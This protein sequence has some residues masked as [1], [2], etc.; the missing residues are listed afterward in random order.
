MV[1]S[2]QK[3]ILNLLVYG[4]NQVLW[5]IKVVKLIVPKDSKGNKINTIYFE[6]KNLHFH[7]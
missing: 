5:S 2:V 3:F 1:N 4:T 6:A 7:V